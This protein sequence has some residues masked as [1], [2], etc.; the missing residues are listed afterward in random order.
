VARAVVRTPSAVR[1][2]GRRAV[3]V[4]AI[5]RSCSRSR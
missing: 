1:P 3:V 5:S 2:A 4:V